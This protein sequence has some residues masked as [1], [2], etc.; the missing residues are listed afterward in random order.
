MQ[1][2]QLDNITIENPRARPSDPLSFAVTFSALQ[3][4]PHPLTWKVTYVGSAFSETY[5]Q[6]L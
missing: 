5:D 3:A 6:N 4:L 2:V 1:L